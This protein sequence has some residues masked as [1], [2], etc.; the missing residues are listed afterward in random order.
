MGK[1]RLDFDLAHRLS[2]F[3]EVIEKWIAIAINS[4]SMGKI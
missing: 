2:L 1:L 4:L 3:W